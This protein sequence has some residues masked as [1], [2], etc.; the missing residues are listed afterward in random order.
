MLREA[1]SIELEAVAATFRKDRKATFAP[2]VQWVWDDGDPNPRNAW[3]LFRRTFDLEQSPVSARLRITAD[4][5]YEAYVNGTRIGHGPVRGFLERWMVDTWE[6]G[7]LLTPSQPNVVGVLVL[8]NGVSTFVDVGNRA[9][10]L[11]EIELVH[12]ERSE[13]I[14]TDAGWRV[15]IPAGHETRAN[16]MSCQLGFAEQIDAREFPVGWNLAGFDDRS[17]QAATLV[18]EPNTGAW[19]NLVERDIPPLEEDIVRPTHVERLAF[20]RPFAQTA[21]IDM[22]NHMDP[23]S[24]GHA[25]HITYSGYL[26]TLVRVTEA[27]EVTVVIPWSRFNGLGLDGEWR[28]LADLGS[29][30]GPQRSLTK[31]LEPG[32]HWLVI[33]VSR[34][35]HGD[36]FQVAVDADVPGAVSFVSPLGDSAETPFVTLHGFDGAGPA[37]GLFPR[38]PVIPQDAVSAA[39]T[40]V[41]AEGLQA[42]GEYVVPVPAV[43]VSEVDLFTLSTQPRERTEAPVP[44]AL[45]GVVAGNAA[46]I[47][48]REGLDTEVIFDLGREFSGFIGFDLEAPA[49]VVVDV[50]GFEYLRGNHRENTERLDNSFRYVT[51]SGRQ[52]YTSPTRRGMRFLQVTF[53][54]LDAASGQLRLRDLTVIESHFPASRVG[55]FRCSDS[56]LDDI[57]ELCRR[58]LLACMEDTYVDCPA[59]EQTY[60]VGDAYNS[61]RFA[62]VTVGAEGLTERCLKLAPASAGQTPYFASQ[63]PSGWVAVIPNWTF[64]WVLTCRNHWFRTGDAGFASDLWPAIRVAMNAFREHING[65]GLLDIEAWNLLDWA[66][67]DQPNAGV[68]SHQNCLM[69]MAIDAASVLAAIAGDDAG[70]L[71]MRDA[72]AQMR[73]AINSHLWSDERQG[74]IDSIHA[75]G[76]RSEV[77]S[78][79][80]HMFA[81]LAGIPEGARAERAQSVLMDPPADWVRIGSPWMSAFLYDELANLGRTED[82]L[83]D[84][85][86]NYG[87]MLDHD[88]TTTWEVYP[89]SPVAADNEQLTRSHCHAWSAAPAAFL[90]ERILGI[91]PAAPGWTTVL[92]APEPCG[93]TWADGSVPLPGE[94]RID[95][96]WRIGDDGRM[97][98]EVRAPEEIAIDARLPQGVIGQATVN[99]VLQ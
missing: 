57:W 74:Y 96:T 79:Q 84:I 39:H 9:G 48:V 12:D 7:H 49:G 58:T 1:T 34:N 75:D 20:V 35:D 53:R 97:F 17:W 13:W 70:S 37:T 86:Q 5:R 50:Y 21:T 43:Y 93:L 85:R 25:N 78:V 29:G 41:S 65:D 68:V 89:A 28:E 22:R 59:Y 15:T 6:I 90:P 82:A 38:I 94:G 98:L 51:R 80:T 44:A 52:R 18:T 69:V 76:V 64:L 67:M 10:L 23:A 88:A 99:G 8:H 26:L 54:G 32:D 45:Q 42:F 36:G 33:D 2:G 47:P 11:A 31:R 91:R 3:R 87:M 16:R 61:A 60:W 55:K 73:Q 46:T 4:T 92:V 40:L 24:A 14:G 30:P 81:L 72:A 77:C 63:V 27:A 71:E 19:P 66:P 95:V 83:A 62:T 56:R